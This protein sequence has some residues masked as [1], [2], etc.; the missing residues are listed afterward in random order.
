MP[1]S[2][3]ILRSD[4]GRI[5]FTPNGIPLT[6]HQYEFEENGLPVQVFYLILEDRSAAHGRIVG[7]LVEERL[8]L[9]WE[10]R[11]LTGQ[12]AV[13]VAIR[14]IDSPSLA[15]EALRHE[16]A[17]WISPLKDAADAP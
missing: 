4:L 5:D 10:G 11:R 9:V 16:L 14:G 6:F 8:R 15:A 12:T 1:A 2:G 13:H 3:A 7:S 17:S